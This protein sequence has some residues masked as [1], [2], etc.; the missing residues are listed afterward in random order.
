MKSINRWKERHVLIFE[1][2]G[3]LVVG[4]NQSSEW[5]TRW[6]DSSWSSTNLH[7]YAGHAADTWVYADRRVQI[8]IPPMSYVMF[9]PKEF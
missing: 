7:D 2:E 6:I 9:A 5:Q 8:V 1:R 4:I 3:N